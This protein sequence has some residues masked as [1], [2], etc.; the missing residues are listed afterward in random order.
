M[1]VTRER[2]RQLTEKAELAVKRRL[3]LA[4]LSPGELLP[5]APPDWPSD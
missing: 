5:A 1:N 2:V 3:K 4:K